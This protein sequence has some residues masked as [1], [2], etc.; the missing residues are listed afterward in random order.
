M[1]NVHYGSKV[2]VRRKIIFFNR[3]NILIC[4]CTL[5]L[6]KVT[7][8]TFIMFQKCSILKHAF[9]LNYSPKN[10][11]NQMYLSLH[12]NIKQHDCFQH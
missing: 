7:V 4:K 12:K 2:G 11:E 1:L 5:N 6:S 8:N 9:P 10:P 3:N